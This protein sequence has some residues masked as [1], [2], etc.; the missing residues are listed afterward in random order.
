MEK[1]GT[2]QLLELYETGFVESEHVDDTGASFLKICLP[3]IEFE[4]LLERGAKRVALPE[5]VNED[6]KLAIES[7]VA[8]AT[9]ISRSLEN[10]KK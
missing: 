6:V 10:Q 4:K 9:I 1:C 7:N 5:L 2:I 8:A 3:R